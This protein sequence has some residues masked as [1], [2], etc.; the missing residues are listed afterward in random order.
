MA[1]LSITRRPRSP[2]DS[3]RFSTERRPA[4]SSQVHLP[5]ACRRPSAWTRMTADREACQTNT[6][7]R[8]PARTPSRHPCAS[9]ASL[10]PWFHQKLEFAV[11]RSAGACAPATAKARGSSASRPASPS[12]LLPPSRPLQ[13]APSEAP[14]IPTHTARHLSNHNQFRNIKEK[15]HENVPGK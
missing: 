9:R 11:R 8:T 10:T 15:S 5:G 14:A 6:A 12:R 3:L 7:I 4:D 13:A 2:C 1:V